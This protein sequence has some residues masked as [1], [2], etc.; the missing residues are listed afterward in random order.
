MIVPLLGI[1]FTRDCNGVKETLCPS[2]DSQI[3]FTQKHHGGLES[4][5]LQVLMEMKNVD[6]IKRKHSKRV[7][8]L[9]T[10]EIPDFRIHLRVSMLSS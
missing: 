10:V 7:L 1:W 8:I 2:G 5:F 9:S 3:L 4:H 6:K